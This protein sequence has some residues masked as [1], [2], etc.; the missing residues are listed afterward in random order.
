MF[1]SD[2]SP[3][4][5]AGLIFAESSTRISVSFDSENRSS[6]FRLNSALTCAVTVTV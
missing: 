2:A 6:Y 3:A 5:G 4:T 1:V